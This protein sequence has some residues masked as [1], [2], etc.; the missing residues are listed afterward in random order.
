MA[1][2][3][4]RVQMVTDEVVGKNQVHVSNLKVIYEK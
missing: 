1:K 3:G 4:W 2:L